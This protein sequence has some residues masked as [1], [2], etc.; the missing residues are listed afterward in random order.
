MKDTI[1]AALGEQLI[2]RERKENIKEKASL[3]TQ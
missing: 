2:K 3:L 1:M